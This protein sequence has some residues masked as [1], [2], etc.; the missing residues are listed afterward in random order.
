MFSNL[1]AHLV[2]IITLNS[3][4]MSTNNKA[5][6]EIISEADAEEA[7][8]RLE[9]QNDRCEVFPYCACPNAIRVTNIF[10]AA[11]LCSIGYKRHALDCE[12]E[13][14]L[15]AVVFLKDEQV[16]KFWDSYESYY[17]G[18]LSVPLMKY[19]KAL[20]EFESHC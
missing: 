2:R 5:E 19:R 8:V 6:G 11:A 17:K 16:Q 1:K 7:R 20:A 4:N 12:D 15:I 10:L 13:G 18:T 3:R 9:M 14:G